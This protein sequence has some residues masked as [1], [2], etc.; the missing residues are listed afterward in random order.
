MTLVDTSVWI[1]FIEGGDHWTK[2][3]LKEKIEDR[4]TIAFLD[5]ILL[6]IVQGIRLRKE[7]ERIERKFGVLTCLAV[8]RSSV[9]LAGEIYQELKKNGVTIRSI[10][11]CLIA[12]VATETGAI[13]LHRDRDF[14]QIEQHYPI[15]VEK[16]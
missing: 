7:R 15:V 11:D 5:L 8:K 14:D 3:R 4:E 10:I 16:P 1:Q 6:E 13:I 2:K 9:M 12:A